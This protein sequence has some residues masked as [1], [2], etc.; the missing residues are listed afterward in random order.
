MSVLDPQRLHSFIKRERVA[1]EY[2][3]KLGGLSCTD[4]PGEQKARSLSGRQSHRTGATRAQLADWTSEGPNGESAPCELESALLSRVLQTVR[5]D[6]RIESI[7]CK[8]GVDS[9]Y[10][11][12]KRNEY[13]S[14]PTASPI[15]TE[16]VTSMESRTGH[17][18]WRATDIRH[19]F[20]T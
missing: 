1:R 14:S 9:L 8:A 7:P 20:S 15:R 11:W 10:C 12:M 16:T 18:A 4:K 5:A 6:L 13:S 3:H 19:D 17:E 2:S